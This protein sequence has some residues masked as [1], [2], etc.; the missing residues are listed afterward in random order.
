V[1]DSRLSDDL[2]D[3]RQH[4]AFETLD[5]LRVEMT[6]T[7]DNP[8]VPKLAGRLGFT[9]EG[10]LRK[11]AV[12]RAQRVDVLWFGVLREEWTAV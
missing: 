4:V 12:E 5:L 6:T 7:P 10:T 2:E 8:V 1:F 3:K 9:Y 11:R